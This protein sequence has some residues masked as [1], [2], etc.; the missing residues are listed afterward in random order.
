LKDRG[1]VSIRYDKELKAVWIYQ[2]PEDRA[3]LTMSMIKSGHELQKA[4]IDYFH[5]SRVID[6]FP[7]NYLIVAS[8]SN[9]VFSFGGDLEHFLSLIKNKK[10]DELLEYTKL[11]VDNL[12]LYKTNLSLP[13]QTI[14]FL[15]GDAFGGGFELALS[16]SYIVAKEGIKLGFPESRFN[17]FPGIGGYTFLSNSLGMNQADKII[18][19]GKVYSAKEMFHLGLISSLAKEG[20]E[21][22]ELKKFIKNLDRSHQ[23]ISL[24]TK[25]KN[26][27]NPIRYDELFMIAKEWSNMIYSLSD[28]EIRV[29]E[30]L[31]NSQHNK[32][33]NR[34]LRTY[35]DRRVVNEKVNIDRRVKERRSA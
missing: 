1:D 18:R 34:Q 35:Q 14:S 21:Y 11:S 22:N 15:Q 33:S 29:L 30:R 20:D 24:L 12:Y 9:G 6:K 7:I 31:V 32:K 26:I 25:A 23:T 2:K 27:R 3:V 8:Q 5:K 16:C 4:I 13:I 17:L 19:E 28:K 10:R